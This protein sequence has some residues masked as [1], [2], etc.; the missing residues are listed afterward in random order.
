MEQRYEL[1]EFDTNIEDAGRL[2][3]G[4]PIRY[5]PTQEEMDTKVRRHL[6]HDA[7]VIVNARHVDDPDAPKAPEIK[8]F[9]K[10]D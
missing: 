6:G 7:F 4:T 10:E 5:G 8:V 2:P 9:R 1:F 3:N